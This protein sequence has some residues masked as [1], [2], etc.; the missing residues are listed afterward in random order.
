M[1]VPSAWRTVFVLCMSAAM[2]GCTIGPDYA[3]PKLTPP[4]SFRGQVTASEATS[5]ADM[6]WWGAFGDPTLQ[7]LI[8]EALGANYDLRI[9]AAR[10]E[11]ARQQAAIARAAFFPSVGYKADAQRSK[12]V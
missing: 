12:G 8:K 6:P 5:L 4:D 2:V 1:I 10:V 11:E 7:A 3:R 9:A